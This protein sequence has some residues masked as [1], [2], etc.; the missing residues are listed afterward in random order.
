MRSVE[1]PIEALAVPTDSHINRRTQ[2]L[3]DST[4]R[5]ELHVVDP[6]G[7]HLRNQLS[8]NSDD[9]GEI[10]LTPAAPNP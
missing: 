9:I 6:T 10:L 4:Q 2:R 3:T 8:G 1:K 7:L 5:P